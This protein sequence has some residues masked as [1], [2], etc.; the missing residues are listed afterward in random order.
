MTPFRIRPTR[1]EDA[2]ALPDVERS[3]AQRFHAVPGLEWIADDAVQDENRHGELIRHGLAWV[4][5]V[6]DDPPLGFLNGEVTGRDLHLWEISVASPHQGHGVG[7][8]LMAAAIA[9]ARRL[10]L[11]RVTLSTFRAVSFNE[12]FYHRLGFRTLSASQLDD[13][14]RRVLAD[15][16]RHGMP[17]E[18]RCAMAF[19]LCP[20]SGD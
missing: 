8:A 6:A 18:R 5:V 4:A 17:P 9:E 1:P 2:A 14:L 12:G 20:H 7:R 10:G 16:A 13:R 3:A 11:E 15:E 19:G